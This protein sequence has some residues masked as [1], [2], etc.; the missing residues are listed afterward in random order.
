[1]RFVTVVELGGKTATGFAVPAEVVEGLGGGRRPA[2]TVRLKGHSY[3]S[4]VATMGGRF[5]V[6]LSAENRAAA[7]LGAGDEVEVELELDAAPRDVS[8]PDDLAAALLEDPQA[9]AVF[10]KLAYSHQRRWV[11]W[12]EGAKKAETRASRVERTIAELRGPG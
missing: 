4:T 1:M 8:V 11:L 5:M 12:V 6:P 2:V 3:R 10:D 7:G 9:K